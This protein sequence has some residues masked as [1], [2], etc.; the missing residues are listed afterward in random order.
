MGKG[1]VLIIGPFSEAGGRE[2]MTAFIAE[3]LQDKYDVDVLSMTNISKKSEVCFLGHKGSVQSLDELMY[4]GHFLLRLIT[5]FLKFTKNI[6][7]E[8]HF[9]VNNKISNFL[10][11]LKTI[12]V[13]EFKKKLKRYD[14]VIINAEVKDGYYIDAI[15]FC[16]QNG[17]ELIYRTTG[18]VGMVS[19]KVKKKL[20]KINTFIHHSKFNASNLDKY[21]EHKYCLIDQCAFSEKSLLTLPIGNKKPLIYG[22]IGRFGE[23][24]GI[25][26]FINMV[27]ELNQKTIIAGDGPLKGEILKLIEKQDGIEYIGFI[28]NENIQEFFNK[29]DVLVISSLHE[30]GPLVGIEALAAGKI[31]VSTKVGAME[32][33][34]EGLT[35]FW[36]DINDKNSFKKV[37]DTLQS[38]DIEELDR[39]SEE[40]RKRY[41]EAHS[42]ELV[43]QKY[44]RLV[45]S[46]LS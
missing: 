2:L 16:H 32:E 24:K 18:T 7:S 26:P 46:I 19:D 21:L 38:M 42:I 31:I 28:A 35:S 30:A 4:K 11:P 17:I 33:R 13:E 43:K 37:V 5:Y 20:Q 40:N 9:I 45:E 23:E 41:I 1:K 25:I 10:L 14:L 12:C 44:S 8:N 29:I 6:K 22:Y 36:M 15:E 39:L 27:T 3:T 34:M